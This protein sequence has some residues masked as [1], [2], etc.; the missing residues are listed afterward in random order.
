M[1]LSRPRGGMVGFLVV[2]RLQDTH[3]TAGSPFPLFV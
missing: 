2:L 1:S 3:G